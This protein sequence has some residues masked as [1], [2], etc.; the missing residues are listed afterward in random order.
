MCGLSAREI[1]SDKES[2][3]D[4]PEEEEEEEAMVDGWADGWMGKIPIPIT[5]VDVINNKR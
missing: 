4:E 1:W 2:A 3:I 5:T